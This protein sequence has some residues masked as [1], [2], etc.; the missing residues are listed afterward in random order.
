MVPQESQMGAER[1]Q[2]DTPQ[3]HGW[4]RD[5]IQNQMK[6]YKEKHD[7]AIAYNGRAREAH[8]AKKLIKP[9]DF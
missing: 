1:R 8:E 6:T 3:L 5:D 4:N 9:M 7:V 2:N